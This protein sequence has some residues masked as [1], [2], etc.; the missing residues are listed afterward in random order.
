M[1]TRLLGFVL[2]CLC[3]EAS[4]I[5]LNWYIVYSAIESAKGMP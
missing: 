3:M 1:K 4:V 5:L 2:A